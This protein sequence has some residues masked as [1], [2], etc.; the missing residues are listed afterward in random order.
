[1]IESYEFGKIVVRGKEYTSDVIVYEDHVD[2]TWQRRQSHYLADY[3]IPDVIADLPEV[4]I[5]GTG[6]AGLAATL[7]SR[8]LGLSVLL[9]EKMAALAEIEKGR[10]RLA[11]ARRW[12]GSAVAAAQDLLHAIG[13]GTS[14][15][16]MGA[17]ARAQQEASAA[18]TKARGAFVIGVSEER[19]PLFD[20]WIEIPPMEEILYPL[21]TV[22]PLQLLA[23]L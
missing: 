14:G 15:L 9:L 7:T 8:D 17:V 10:G 5:V 3:D 22:V 18:E 23:Y 19:N 20:E 6:Y 12:A 4:V 16:N 13:T 2:H 11:E 1:M 21:V